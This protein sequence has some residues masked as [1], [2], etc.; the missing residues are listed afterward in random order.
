MI[1]LHLIIINLIGNYINEDPLIMIHM[2]LASITIAIAMFACISAAEYIF[3]D[4]HED[5]HEDN[6]NDNYNDTNDNRIPF[7]RSNTYHLGPT[8]T[9]N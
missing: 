1:K 7:N 5:N 8:I 4:N 9:L 3:N 6:P 2:N